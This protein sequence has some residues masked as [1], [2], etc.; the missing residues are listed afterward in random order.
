MSMRTRKI[1]LAV[2]CAL[3]AVLGLTSCASYSSK[4]WVATDGYWYRWTPAN[5]DWAHPVMYVHCPNGGCNEPVNAIL[6]WGRQTNLNIAYGTTGQWNWIAGETNPY[7]VGN[8]G[9]SG[10]GGLA[11]LWSCVRSTNGYGGCR[12]GQA[13]TNTYYGGDS[14][15]RLGVACQEAGHMWGMDHADG[16]CMG[17]GYFSHANSSLQQWTVDGMHALRYYANCSSPC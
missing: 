6:A 5:G 7:W 1:I 13:R 2:L 10:Y 8:F 17:L 11:E 4:A 14:N 15:Y 9:D 12:S 16:D 3:P